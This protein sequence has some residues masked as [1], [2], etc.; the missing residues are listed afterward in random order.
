MQL[1]E[2]AATFLCNVFI[3]FPSCSLCPGSWV[4]LLL[5]G[6][7]CVVTP[8]SYLSL[9]EASHT[10]LTGGTCVC[11]CVL[12]QRAL[13]WQKCSGKRKSCMTGLRNSWFCLHLFL[14][15]EEE[16]INLVCPA[17]TWAWPSH[18]PVKSSAHLLSLFKSELQRETWRL[19]CSYNY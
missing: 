14:H 15:S 8:A 11:V 10:G 1:R 4:C 2:E 9:T 13:S 17:D 6:E 7:E 18:P 3:R 19:C 5:E 16:Q 12:P